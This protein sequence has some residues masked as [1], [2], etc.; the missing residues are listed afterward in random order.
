MKLNKISSAVFLTV[1]LS[2]SVAF[3]QKADW[4]P[5]KSPDP[6]LNKEI[7]QSYTSVATVPKQAY[8]VPTLVE[9]DFEAST[10]TGFTFGVYNE[11]LKQFVPS[12]FINKAQDVATVYLATELNKNTQVNRIVDKNLN[13]F[14]DFYLDNLET[15]NFVTI[16]IAYS[17]N[18][19]SD[20]L[21]LDLANNVALPE[22]VS[23]QALS[24]NSYVTVVAKKRMTSRTVSFPKTNAYAWTVQLHYSQPLRIAEL[25]FNNFDNT[26][27][28]KSVKFLY[29]PN[30]SYTVYANQMKNVA[31]YVDGQAGNIL[32]NNTGLKN[33]GTLTLR[34]NPA[35][36][37]SDT[38]AD[39]IA[40][41]SDNCMSLSNFDQKDEDGNGVGD[42]CDDYD[43]DG[44]VN[45]KD[46]C[47]NLPS[48]NQ[49]DT[50]GDGIGDMCDEE[51]SRLTEKY[52]V[53]VW[54]AIAFATLI[55]FGLLYMAFVKMKL[56][57]KA[58][59]LPTQNPNDPNKLN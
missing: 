18:I 33:I 17:K 48:Y 54:G 37:P 47:P 53:I 32:F 2:T 6:V 34:D 25:S 29:Q 56:N 19:T 5:V 26:I 14:Q 49:Y 52:P 51:E 7:M 58:S 45:S 39:G 50:D 9:A 11:T 3:A 13:T 43:K 42:V 55:L 12:V 28:K 22:Y 21:Q 15:E 20:T 23:V 10:V 35:Y 4:Q 1:L 41:S 16:N 30:N 46:N 8:T 40:D 38:D 31:S 24:G 57:S 27:S 59:T 36:V 44:Y